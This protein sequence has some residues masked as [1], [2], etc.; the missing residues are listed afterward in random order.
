[1]IGSLCRE[2]PFRCLAQKVPGTDF[3]RSFATSKHLRDAS[4]VGLQSNRLT[5]QLIYQL[6]SVLL[7]S[8][9][10]NLVLCFLLPAFFGIGAAWLINHANY[11]YRDAK[12]GP[13]GMDDTVTIANLGEHVRLDAEGTQGVGRLELVGE[14]TF[15]FGV[16]TPGK[17]GE[18]RFTIRNVGDGPLSLRVGASTCKCTLGELT[19]T[20]L[21]PSEET[22]ITLTWTPKAGQPVFKQTAELISNDP[23]Q[24]AIALHIVG[25]VISDFELSPMTWTFGEVA[26]GESFEI[27]GEIYNFSSH[28]IEP[29]TVSFSND[30]LNEFAEIDVQPIPAEEIDEGRKQA[31]EGFR[32]VA[33]V[34]PGLGEKSIAQNLLFNYQRTE[35]VKPESEEGE[36]KLRNTKLDDDDWQ[37]PVSVK[38]R[39]VGPLRMIESSKLKARAGG[40]YLLR[41]GRVRS[42]DKLKSKAFLVLKGKDRETTKLSVGEVSPAG[43]LRATLGE[44][45]GRGKMVLYPLT[46]ELVPGEKPVERLGKNKEDFGKVMIQAD[47]PKVGKMGIAVTFAI[48]GR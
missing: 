38:G 15:D 19:K 18:H 13:F 16:M 22:E 26:T 39:I 23:A 47:N 35:R 4:K 28:K 9:M 2:R 8:N 36:N 30:E 3:S 37:L 33:R 12:F 1:M 11:G 14:P 17:E 7:S 44:P 27:K 40:G 5:I 31:V 20:S 29:T 34:R 10:K 48:D 21:E 42:G 45:T 43:T 41:L 32:I 24:P 6:S 46:L 25:K